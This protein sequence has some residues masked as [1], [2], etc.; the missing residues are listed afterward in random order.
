MLGLT[1]IDISTVFFSDINA[2]AQPGSAFDTAVTV[3]L[4]HRAVFDDFGFSTAFD[5]WTLTSL[6]STGLVQTRPGGYSMTISGSG[7]GP[8]SSLDDLRVAIDN[9]LATGTLNTMVLARNGAEF[10]RVNLSTTGYSLISGNQSITLSGGLV[11]SFAQLNNLTEL[12]G[13]ADLDMLYDM[14]DAE[15]TQVF[16]D[17]AAYGL[18]GLTLQ[19]AGRT[20]FNLAVSTSALTLSIGGYQLAITGDFPTD[21]GAVLSLAFDAHRA[22]LEGGIDQAE[23]L[24]A[25]LNM[26]SV[27]F[28]NPAGLLLLSMSG[29]IEANAESI[30]RIDGVEITGDIVSDLTSNGTFLWAEDWGQGLGHAV[31]G[32]L[33]GDELFSQSGNDLLYGFD[34]ADYMSGG[35][36]DD[37]LYG[38]VGDD[39]LFGGLGNDLIGGGLGDD[40]IADSGGGR[41]RIWGGL[42]NDSIYGGADSDEIYGGDGRNQLYGNDGNDTLTAGA[43]SDTL[44]GGAGNDALY[45]GA[46]ANTLY[47]GIGNDLAGGG[48]G[49]DLIYGGAGSNQIWGGLDNDTVQGGTGDDAIYG[50]PGVNQLYGNAGNDVI[51]AGGS[52][53]LLAGGVGNDILYGGAGNDTL[54]LGS[55]NDLAGAGAGNDLIYAGAG[56]NQIW[57]GVGND[58]IIAGLGRDIID[59]GAGADQFVFGSTSSLGIGSNRDVII[60]FATGDRINLAALHL[61]F[62]GSEAFGHVAGQ[63]RSIAG[64]VIGDLD[65]DGV[66]DFSI[67]IAGGATLGSGDFIL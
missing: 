6:T 47:L 17:F 52:G 61:S 2:S 4:D 34:G 8:V 43:G 44:A 5:D 28:S 63:L 57:A 37:S 14:S 51:T 33:G 36:G 27:S 46:G 24:L 41:N 49:N 10:F 38:G 42:G 15:R 23:T 16:S 19:D 66:T 13:L 9:G 3:T 20:V 11:N 26:T 48:A 62:I 22:F 35:A 31:M 60:G 50:G 67:E 25:G 54:Y 7:V 53:D 29:Q 45:G 1:T 12:V 40:W 18:T 32:T 65:G 39:S 56:N 58:T 59:G 21:M 64:F 55:G 30:T